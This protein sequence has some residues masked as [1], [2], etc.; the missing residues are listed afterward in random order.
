M[1]NYLMKMKKNSSKILNIITLSAAGI[2]SLYFAVYLVLCLLGFDLYRMSLIAIFVIAC[3]TLPIILHEQLKKLFKGAFHVLHIIFTS[4]LCVFIVTLAAFWCYIGFDSQKNSDGYTISAS[5]IGDTG[6]G[7]AIMVYG[8]HTNGYTPGVTLKL[9]LDE[10]YN[11]LNAL[12][13]SICVVSGG[14]GSNETISEAE[15]MKHYLTELGIDPDRI[16]MEDKSH[17]TSENVRFTKQLLEDMNIEPERIIGVSTAFHLPRIEMLTRRYDLPMEVCAAPSPN[18]A[19]YY[20][21]MVREYLSYIKMVL[22]DDLV[23]EV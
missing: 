6:V 7:T 17:T 11:L 16:L 3:V 4:L 5:A 9:R 15:A 22:F 21:S 8:C 12:P 19:Q 1:I 18:F 20:V 13:D 14:Q 23:I 2:V 10:A